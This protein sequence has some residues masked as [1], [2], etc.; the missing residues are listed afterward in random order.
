MQGTF[1]TSRPWSRYSTVTH[2]AGSQP[3]QATNFGDSKRV[4]AWIAAQCGSIQKSNQK[5]VTILAPSRIQGQ[6]KDMDRYP[7]ITILER[8]WFTRARAEGGKK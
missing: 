8:G 3:L 2:M 4:T 7:V 6:F 1:A 5:L